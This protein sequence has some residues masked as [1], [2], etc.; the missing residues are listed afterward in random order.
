MGH[1]EERAEP[2]G[3]VDEA[4]HLR[5]RLLR[6]AD[7][8]HARVVHRVD[9]LVGG[10][11]VLGRQRQCRHALEVV[12][13]LRQAERDVGSGLLFSFGDMHRADEPP[14]LAV[15]GR[16]ELLGPF[17]HNRPVRAENVEAAATRGAD[18]QQVQPEPPGQAGTRR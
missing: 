17:F 5:D 3:L 7:H 16:A 2:P 6:C 9:H 4:L 13:P 12:H 18:G 8:R 15:D 11:G 1:E 10:V 14:L